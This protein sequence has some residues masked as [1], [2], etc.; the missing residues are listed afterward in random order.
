MTRSTLM[1]SAALSALCATPALA[2]DD[3]YDLG[4]LILSAGLEA[5]PA[6]ETG[7]SAAV[8]CACSPAPF[9]HV[10]ALSR[11]T[12]T[13]RRPKSGRSLPAASRAADSI[14]LLGAEA[15]ESAPPHKKA[16]GASGSFSPVLKS[17]AFKPPA[18]GRKSHSHRSATR[19]S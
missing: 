18:P 17:P 8:R 13:R 11:T 15:R 2:Q 4:V 10:A 12:R 9:A 6:D 5:A 14:S 7:V 1:T 16:T 19:A 3:A